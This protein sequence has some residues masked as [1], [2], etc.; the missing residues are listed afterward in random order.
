LEI[1]NCSGNCG[2]DD[3]GIKNLTKLKILSASDNPKIT[4]INHLTNLEILWCDGNC[5]ISDEGIKN[6]T[7]LKEMYARNNPKI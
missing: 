5:G 1:L 7:N 2:I 4:N 6:L 3:K